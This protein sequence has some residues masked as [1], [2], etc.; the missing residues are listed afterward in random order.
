MLEFSTTRSRKDPGRRCGSTAWSGGRRLA[1]ACRRVAMEILFALAMAGLG[2][3]QEAE[4]K[5]IDLTD[6]VQACPADRCS[7]LDWT[8]PDPNDLHLVQHLGSPSGS[9]NG[10]SLSRLFDDSSPNVVAGPMGQAGSAAYGPGI[11]GSAMAM[12][13]RPWGWQ[14]LPDGLIYHSYMAGVKEPRLGCAW[15]YEKHWGWMWDITLGGRVGILRYGTDDDGVRPQGF[16]L[17]LEGAAMPRLD[18]EHER[19]V[20]SAD[21]RAGVPLTFGIGAYQT[22]FGYYHLSSHLGDEFMLR[23][24][25]V[26]RINYSRDVLI[27]GHSL[28]LC[29]DLRVYAEA[30]WAFYYDGGTKP[31][32]FQFGIDYSPVAATG[33]FR[34]AP[35]AAIN[36]QIQQELNYSGRLVTQAGW[37]WRSDSGQVL[38]TGVQYFTGN[39]EQFEFY[40]DYEEKVG[41]GIWYDF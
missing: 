20:I 19:D 24:P 3:G 11:S 21:F 4:R 33:S 14:L 38:R 40:R 15:N 23:F 17:D 1:A 25:S 30:G 16:Q 9:A 7:L 6:D 8:R 41:W 5:P 12:S 27:W 35:F 22:K 39:S 26:E 18:L 13:D 2:W 32:E 10:G 28:Y 36:W 34:G 37:Q 31:W 29:D